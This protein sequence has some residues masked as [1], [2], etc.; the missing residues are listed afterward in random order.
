MKTSMIGGNPRRT[1]TKAA[2][3]SP[4]NPVGTPFGSMC[5]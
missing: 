4:A 5:E 1:L 3:K 2:A